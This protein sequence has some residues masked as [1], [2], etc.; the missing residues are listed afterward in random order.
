MKLALSTFTFVTFILFVAPENLWVPKG[1]ELFYSFLS[2]QN[3]VAEG[4]YQVTFI[5]DW[6]IFEI[7]NLEEILWRSYWYHI[8]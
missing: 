4:E 3:L 2:P 7:I 1:Q 6:R 5:E 8:F